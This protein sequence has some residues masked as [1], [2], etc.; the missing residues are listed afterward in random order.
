M[1][2]GGLRDWSDRCRQLRHLA[3]QPQLRDVGESQSRQGRG[4]QITH[5]WSGRFMP[6]EV[7]KT[8]GAPEGA[9]VA[10]TAVPERI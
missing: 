8:A 2:S 5:R 10:A 7:E 3:A 4:G 1:V 6:E 9:R